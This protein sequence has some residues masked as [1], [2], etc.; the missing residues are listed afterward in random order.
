MAIMP[1]EIKQQK[2][3]K[4]ELRNI[5]KDAF[6]EVAKTS[7][8]MVFKDIKKSPVNENVRTTNYQKLSLSTRYC[9]ER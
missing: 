2:W 7:S 8:F 6:K 5:S 1:R 9:I 3:L 4:E